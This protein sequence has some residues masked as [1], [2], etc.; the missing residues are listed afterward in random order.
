VEAEV[1]FE[2]TDRL[3]RTTERKFRV[4]E[5]RACRLL[6]LDPRPKPEELRQYY[7]ENYWFAPDATA[8]GRMEEAYRRFVLG[9]HVSFV[10]RA[11]EDS[12]ESGPV[13]DVGCGGGLFLRVLREQGSS[14]LGIDQSFPAA[15][16]AWRVNAVPAIHGSLTEAPLAASS[17]A[18]ITM[19][20]VLEH[21]DQPSRHLHAAHELLRPQGRL[22]VQTPNAACWQFLLLGENW[23]GVDVP[24]HLVNYRARD[25]ESL[26]DSCG[27]EVL[28]RKY[29]SLRDNPAGLATSLAPWLDPM[30]RRVRGMREAPAWK[31]AK[32]L[33][34]FALV[35]AA[36]PFTVVEAACRAG[37]TVMIEARKKT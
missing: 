15:S 37:S 3:Y 18:A 26:L 4:V 28:R 25:L 32:D 22:I 10:K 7:P 9:D 6:R 35:V 36:L 8:A 13:L 33:L 29:F 2:T 34:Y 31:L 5:C 1:R 23:S 19:F 20:H 11:L 16:A 24:R 21:L 14:V 27:F 30:A 17:C 12:R